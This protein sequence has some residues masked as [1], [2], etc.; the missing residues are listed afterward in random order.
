MLSCFHLESH[1]KPQRGADCQLLFTD[2]G[3]Q[4]FE[5]E[6]DFSGDAQLTGVPPRRNYHFPG[7]KASSSPS[8]DQA[9]SRLECTCSGTRR[10]F[11]HTPRWTQDL[12][13]GPQCLELTCRGRAPG[14]VT[15]GV[16]H[17]MV[18][19]TAGPAAVCAVIVSR[20]SFYFKLTL[21][22]QK[23]KKTYKD[24]IFRKHLPLLLTSYLAMTPLSEIRNQ[25]RCI[26]I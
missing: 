7:C 13:Y 19:A 5:L 2:A 1:R 24:N 17:T 21:D 3:N 9:T 14:V 11:S 10:C 16:S 26:T 12:T 6:S 23:K 20:L 8:L 18:V 4:R 25:H 15:P 22:L